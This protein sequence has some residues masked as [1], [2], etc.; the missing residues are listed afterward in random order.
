MYG[1]KTKQMILDKYMDEHKKNPSRDTL[2][3]IPAVQFIESFKED[4]R[5][6]V[7]RYIAVL[8]HE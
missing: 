5:D 8:R 2:L 1:Y 7:D 6:D 3:K 4:K